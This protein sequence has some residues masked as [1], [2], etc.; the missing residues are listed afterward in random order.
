MPG[1]GPEGG[2]PPSIV[3]LA[4]RLPLITS[5]TRKRPASRVGTAS[6]AFEAVTSSCALDAWPAPMQIGHATASA[7]SHNNAATN[8]VP[9]KNRRIWDDLLA[10]TA[11]STPLLHP[12]SATRSLAT[13]PLE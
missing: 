6:T 8:T 7:L 13:P 11:P 12:S 9:I 2:Y 4:G 5:V 10:I 3:W 1:T